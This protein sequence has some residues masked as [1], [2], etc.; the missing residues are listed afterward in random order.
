MNSLH[1]LI[2]SLSSGQRRHLS[3]WL[4]QNYSSEALTSLF[5]FIAKHERISDEKIKK[6]FK[7]KKWIKYLPVVK[8][9]LYKAVLQGIATLNQNHYTVRSKLLQE[10]LYADTLMGL[11]M[12][13]D[14]I[15]KLKSIIEKAQKLGF[16]TIAIEALHMQIRATIYKRGNSLN[17][18]T[19]KHFEELFLELK[20][21]NE[22]LWNN[23]VALLYSERIYNFKAGSPL[24]DNEEPLLK[25]FIDHSSNL[26][27]T[28]LP[29]AS[30]LTIYYFLRAASLTTVLENKNYNEIY[31]HLLV[32]TEKIYNDPSYISALPVQCS[33]IIH[34]VAMWLASNGEFQKAID[35]IPH[36]L[37]AEKHATNKMAL[38]QIHQFYLVALAYIIALDPYSAFAQQVVQ[39]INNLQPYI[40][41]IR[42]TKNDSY[43]LVMYSILKN[44]MVQEKYQSAK[45]YADFFIDNTYKEE[46]GLIKIWGFAL[47][48][49]ALYYYNNFNSDRLNSAIRKAEY[50]FKQLDEWD[51]PI[52]NIVN[53]IKNLV[54]KEPTKSSMQKLNQLEYNNEQISIFNIG[55][56][57]NVINNIIQPSTVSSPEMLHTK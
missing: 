3:R 9:N 13:D 26:I 16:P 42:D 19:V 17:L 41:N 2:R 28:P 53:F 55:H 23:F 36:L 15:Y 39:D 1:K 45:E 31:E 44:L 48:L 5:E 27:K 8:S 38:S 35:T 46:L 10:L 50:K 57:I 11:E 25:E 22:A 14:A 6:K 21:D 43:I 37:N 54:Y 18:E 20:K 51:P 12:Y 33:Y 29:N 52:S 40:K 47:I 49:S 4:K 56:I 7:N 30:F 24:E 32:L 34:T